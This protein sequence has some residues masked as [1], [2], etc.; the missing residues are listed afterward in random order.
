MTVMCLPLLAFLLS[1]CAS[2]E[3]ELPPQPPT[4]PLSPVSDMEEESRRS[5]YLRDIRPRVV[6]YDGQSGDAPAVPTIL[7]NEDFTSG[8][9]LPTGT[10]L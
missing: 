4:P 10:G 8:G 3:K 6:T 2:T 5:S 9:F 1:S 7:S